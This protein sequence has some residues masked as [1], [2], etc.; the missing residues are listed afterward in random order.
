MYLASGLDVRSYPVPAADPTIYCNVFPL[1]K[2]A[3]SSACDAASDP[4]QAMNEI[5]VFRKY[6]VIATLP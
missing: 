2:L 6:P 4:V 3:T 1:K 5:V